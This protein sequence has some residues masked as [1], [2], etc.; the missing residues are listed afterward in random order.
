MH[1]L[2]AKSY[3][4][5]D[6]FQ[7]ETERI[8]AQEW[9]PIAHTSEFLENRYAI[10]RRFVQYSIVLVRDQETYRAFHNVC[11]HRA[12]PLLWK[13]DCGP[14]KALRCRYHGWRYNLEG[15]CTHQPDFGTQ[16][17]ASL[18]TIHV[19]IWKGV[20]FVSLVK[21]PPPFRWAAIL[22]DHAPSLLPFV[23]HRTATHR[24]A[25]NWKTAVMISLN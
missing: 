15:L 20:I 10:E 3:T 11:P 12:G 25:C 7:K 18:Q 16:V 13:G 21:N 19:Q 14:L 1:T 23:F 22:S 4:D 2:H 17:D 5:P 8:F 6:V 24:I 9:I